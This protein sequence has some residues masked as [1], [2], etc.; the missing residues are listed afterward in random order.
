MTQVDRLYKHSIAGFELTATGVNCGQL[1]LY[2]VGT[3]WF[4]RLTENC[5]GWLVV[6]VAGATVPLLRVQL[7]Y[8]P[9]WKF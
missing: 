9:D 3:V 4:C 5:R 2:Q 6:L 7:T 1:E 8:E